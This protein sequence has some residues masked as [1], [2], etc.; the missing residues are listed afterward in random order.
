MCF[1]LFVAV[2]VK[3]VLFYNTKMG[4]FDLMTMKWSFTVQFSYEF[5]VL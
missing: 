2:Y 5:D 3:L 4:G 1:S